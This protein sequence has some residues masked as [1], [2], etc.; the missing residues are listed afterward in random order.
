[1]TTNSPEVRQYEG[2]EDPTT[3]QRGIRECEA[4]WNSN[5][6]LRIGTLDDL[7][8]NQLN[9]ALEQGRNLVKVLDMG[10]GD[11]SLMRSAVNDRID[12]SGKSILNASRGILAQNPD[13]RIRIVGF[14]DARKTDDFM[15]REPITLSP[16]TIPLTTTYQISAENVHYSVTLKQPVTTLLETLDFQEIDLVLATEFFNHLK[17]DSLFGTTLNQAVDTLRAHG[18]KLVSSSYSKSKTLEEHQAIADQISAEVTRNGITNTLEYAK[19]WQEYLYNLERNPDMSE[20]RKKVLAELEKTD[21]LEFKY[22]PRT[23]IID[24]K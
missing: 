5:R 12:S 2:P 21:G 13:M 9:L 23:L 6:E 24:K 4:V 17:D 20:E 3:F 8:A 15:K 10:S 7:L 1:M 22:G 19:R 18:G 16:Y 11:G 14:T